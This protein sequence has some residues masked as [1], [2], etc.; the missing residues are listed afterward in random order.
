M[1]YI[2]FAATKPQSKLPSKKQIAICDLQRGIGAALEASQG[3]GR[4]A[5]YLNSYHKGIGRTPL[6]KT[7]ASKENLLHSNG[8]LYPTSALRELLFSLY[9]SDT[10]EHLINPISNLFLMPSTTYSK[11]IATQ[12]YAQFKAAPAPVDIGFTSQTVKNGNFIRFS[13]LRYI[14]NLMGTRFDTPGDCSALLHLLASIKHGLDKKSHDASVVVE[15][16]SIQ[17]IINEL[18][19]CAIKCIHNVVEIN[20]KGVKL[21][22]LGN[23]FSL[24][25][26]FIDLEVPVFTASGTLTTH[27][28]NTTINIAEIFECLGAYFQFNYYL[29]DFKQWA[30][31]AMNDSTHKRS[32]D[33]LSELNRAFSECEATYDWLKKPKE[34]AAFI[35]ESYLRHGVSLTQKARLIIEMAIRNPFLNVAFDSLGAKEEQPIDFAMYQLGY[36]PKVYTLTDLAEKNENPDLLDKTRAA[37]E[38]LIKAESCTHPDSVFEICNSFQQ[39]CLS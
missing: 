38:V 13:N 19:C 36:T 2:N 20:M 32:K 26:R 9:L 18:Y 37:N 22:S 21:G 10:A 7:W 31:R 1:D 14:Y 4:S 29:Q 12:I 23:N 8:L 5:F 28:P 17:E 35:A 33:V 11:D 27:L 30:L 3:S 15:P 6:V 24:D 39:L 16:T 34:V 25:G